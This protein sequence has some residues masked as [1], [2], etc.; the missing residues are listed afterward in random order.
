[1][2]NKFK[3]GELVKVNG[4]GKVHGVVKE[5][6]GKVLLRDEYYKDYYIKLLKKYN[7]WFEETALSKV[8]IKSKMKGKVKW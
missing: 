8:K 2:R 1:M 3:Y 4:E 7:D 5:K 6:L